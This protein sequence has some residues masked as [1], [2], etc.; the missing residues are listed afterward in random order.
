VRHLCHV[1]TLRADVISAEKFDLLCAAV[2]NPESFRCDGFH[3][4][5]LARGLEAKGK[6]TG[7]RAP[8]G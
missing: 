1:T 7:L 6:A 3:C 5:D 4:A 2:S 8:P